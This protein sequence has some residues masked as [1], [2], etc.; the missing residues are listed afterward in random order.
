[1]SSD[2]HAKRGEGPSLGLDLSCAR[3]ERAM[4]PPRINPHVYTLVPSINAA[5]Y[6]GQPLFS[7]MCL[8]RRPSTT[9]EI[10]CARR[11]QAARACAMCECERVSVWRVRSDPASHNPHSYIPIKYSTFY[12]P[13][14]PILSSGMFRK[15]TMYLERTRV[16][17]PFKK[18]NSSIFAPL[19]CAT[20]PLCWRPLELT[21]HE[22]NKIFIIKRLSDSFCPTCPT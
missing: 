10:W 15:T 6:L 11:V 8:E 21:V 12:S 9:E 18:E 22:V 16:Q 3:S 13:R 19:R 5:F 14:R 2:V 17:S 7:S 4:T 1:M 20:G